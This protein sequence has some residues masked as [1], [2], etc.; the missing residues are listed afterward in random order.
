MEPSVVTIRIPPAQTE[1]DPVRV[2]AWLTAQ[3]H[4]V[5][6]VAL[7]YSNGDR[8]LIIQTDADVAPLFTNWAAVPRSE[9][10]TAILAYRT[11]TQALLQAASPIPAAVHK[12]W[13][14]DLNDLLR[15][16]FGHLR[17]D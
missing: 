4:V 14:R 16:G 10:R 12:Q 2:H 17:D 7:R 8:D 1:V 3:G 9:L 5:T 11:S 6:S 13:V 15:A